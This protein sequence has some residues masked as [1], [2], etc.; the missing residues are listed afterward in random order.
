MD[1]LI[2]RL[3]H[4]I[5]DL[6]KSDYYT[7]RRDAI[8][9]DQQSRQK[10][11]LKAF[12][13]ETAREGFSVIQVQMGLFVKPDLI[14]VID[15]QPVPFPKLEQAVREKKVRRQS[16]RRPERQ[17][18]PTCP[19]SSKGSSSNL[20]E[21]DESTRLELKSFDEESITP[22]IA[23]ARGRNPG[24]SSPSRRSRNTWTRSRPT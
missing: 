21:I 9:E 15:D 6:L 22:V 16:P 18:T 7:E 1:N 17:N 2:A 3:Q 12:E 20:R 24:P 13:D 11:I 19:K 10:E 8:I 5:P 4:N 14:P 23:G